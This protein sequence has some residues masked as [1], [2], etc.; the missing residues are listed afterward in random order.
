MQMNMKPFSDP[1]TRNVKDIKCPLGL[2]PFD[3]AKLQPGPSIS[4]TY[5]QVRDEEQRDYPKQSDL[6]L[7]AGCAVGLD[8]NGNAQHFY[9]GRIDHFIGFLSGQGEKRAAVKT[10][11]SIVLEIKGVTTADRGKPV[12]CVGPNEFTLKKTAGAAEIGAV[13]YSQGNSRAAV[14]FRR[15]DSDKPL[16]LRLD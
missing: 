5:E 4:R 8:D 11:G 15:Y 16:N 1:F 14:A 6:I 9:A 7:A 3:A 10:R 13:R 2:S 12:Y